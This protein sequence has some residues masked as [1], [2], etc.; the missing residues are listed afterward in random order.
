MLELMKTHS[1]KTKRCP[2][3]KRTVDA[4]TLR[5]LSRTRH[6]SGL[7]YACPDCY[8]RVMALRRVAREARS[9]PQ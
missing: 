8:A 2:E 5:P 7:R 4:T 1:S 9:R 6:G 3:C